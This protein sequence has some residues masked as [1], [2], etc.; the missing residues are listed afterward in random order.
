MNVLRLIG[1]ELIGMFVG[2]NKLALYV[3]AV[4]ALA[5]VCAQVL[6]TSGLVTGMML[7]LGCA[8]VLIESVL[9]AA[10]G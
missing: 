10:R 2:D 8:A 1:K 5:A 6:N 3:L 7:A 4:V 9:R